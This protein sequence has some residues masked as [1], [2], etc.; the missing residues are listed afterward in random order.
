L[1]NKGTT[2]SASIYIIW[3]KLVARPL[4]A[5]SVWPG[6]IPESDRMTFGFLISPW[7]RVKIGAIPKLLELILLL[8]RSPTP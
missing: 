2:G 7:F 8:R 3:R 5:V 1:T 6:M 4:Q